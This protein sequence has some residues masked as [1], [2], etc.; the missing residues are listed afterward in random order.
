[1]MKK[2]SYVFAI[3][4]FVLS[5]QMGYTQS[6]SNFSGTI[7]S[8]MN[9]LVDRSFPYESFKGIRP[10]LSQLRKNV[11]DSINYYKDQRVQ[12]QTTIKAQKT[13]IDSL[14]GTI[15]T[16]SQEL[17]TAIT[18]RDN[19][20]FLGADMSKSAYSS[21]MWGLVIALAIG[22]VFFI[23]RYNNNINVARDSK[24]DLESLKNELESH[25]KRALER[26]QKL[27]R[28][29]QDELNKSAR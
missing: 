25:R 18:A 28:D 17:E 8:Q 5:S 19:F 20:S 26:E 15:Q 14:Q 3:L 16:K 24:K 7:E 29:L 10:S 23:Y 12:E 2:T 13:Q 22:L 6:N 4:I 27:K 9:T 11:L 1:M 21:L